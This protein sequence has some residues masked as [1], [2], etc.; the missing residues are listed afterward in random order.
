MST[1]LTQQELTDL[2]D[3]L[4]PAAQRRWLVAHGWAFEVSASGKIKVLREVMLRKMGGTSI[5]ARRQGPNVEALMEGM[6]LG[7]KKAS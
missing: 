5:A 6:G 2:T 7:K 4:Q 1:F 3:L